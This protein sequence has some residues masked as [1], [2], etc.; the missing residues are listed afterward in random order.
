LTLDRD[1]ILEDPGEIVAAIR[2][3]PETPRM[4]VMEEKLLIEARAKIERHI[5]NGYLKRLDAPV[6]VKPVLKCWMEL[7]E[8]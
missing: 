4:C 2:S 7:N 3:K 1:S 6:G 8:G 5:K